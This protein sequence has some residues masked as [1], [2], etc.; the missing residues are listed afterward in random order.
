MLFEIMILFLKE[1]FVD[2]DG[3]GFFGVISVVICS[4][5]GRGFTLPNIGFV[6]AQDALNQIYD[7]RGS[8]V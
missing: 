5:I 8:A 3:I 2:W 1:M 7:S 6:V 4:Q